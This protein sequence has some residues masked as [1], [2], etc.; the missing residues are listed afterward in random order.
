M[1]GDNITE[2]GEQHS[3]SYWQMEELEQAADKGKMVF[4]IVES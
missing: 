3:I 4:G 1:S 2:W